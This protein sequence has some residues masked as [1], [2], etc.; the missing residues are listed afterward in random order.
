MV[1][2]SPTPSVSELIIVSERL[3]AF[4]GEDGLTI[5]EAGG[6]PALVVDFLNT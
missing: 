1:D 5:M 6:D 2:S 3:N 4:Q